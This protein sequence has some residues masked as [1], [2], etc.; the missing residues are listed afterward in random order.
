MKTFI[1]MISFFVL[2]SI[3]QAQVKTEPI[4]YQDG[5]VELEGFLAYD[6]L[7]KSKRGGVLIIHDK[8]GLNDFTKKRAEELAKLVYIAFALDLFGKDI[9]INEQTDIDELLEPFFDE[10]QA[11]IPQRAQLGLGNLADHSKVDASRI[12]VIGYGFG[13]TVAM[14]LAR[15]GANLSATV[16]YFGKLT[17]LKT[18]TN[19]K[20]K[21]PILILIGSDDP[22]IPRED[23]ESFKVEMNSENNDWQINTYGGAVHGFTYY[24]LGFEPSSGE[25]YNYNADKRSWEAVKILLL[26]TLK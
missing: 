1:I 15:S 23:L 16:N 14:E 5:D 10:N 9:T 21:C 11:L 6:K 4:L 20:I 3:I 22:K 24:E 25:A 12:A 26:E 19:Q 7:L 18:E 8:Y 2:T 17:P 13:G